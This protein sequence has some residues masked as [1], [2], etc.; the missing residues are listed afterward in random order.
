MSNES[1]EIKKDSEYGG[2]LSAIVLIAAL[3]FMVDN[4]NS[5]RE[6][7][8]LRKEFQE[9]KTDF[10]HPLERINANLNDENMRLKDSLRIYKY[11]RDS[12][13]RIIY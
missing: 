1:K 9:F 13:L 2:C 11:D 8:L 6:I 4:W 3:C 5:E 12:L 7:K 10:V